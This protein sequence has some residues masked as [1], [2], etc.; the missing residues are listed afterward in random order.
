MFTSN[1]S[2]IVPP[3]VSRVRVVAIGGGG[4]GAN[5][6]MP[7]GGGGYVACGTFNVTSNST[8]PV[9]V[10]AGGT[11]ALS[12][13]G[14]AIVG[15]SNGFPSKFD[16]MLV[17]PGGYSWPTAPTYYCSTG[18][19]TNGGTGSGCI[20]LGA[21]NGV[22]GG[23]G[24]SGGSNGAGAGTCSIGGLGQGTASYAACLQL[25]TLHKLTAGVG[26]VG[27]S[28]YWESTCCYGTSGGG[29]GILFDGTGPY[30]QNGVQNNLTIQK[31]LLK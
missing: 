9:T 27:G 1:G 14:N 18:Y 11:G 10:G 7:A 21:C 13:T 4:G 20:C 25:V 8:V 24:G 16:N 2:F 22:P 15:I 30:A 29:G 3:H 12:N 23:S 6:Y 19:G 26:G 17:A 28:C 5:G 31:I